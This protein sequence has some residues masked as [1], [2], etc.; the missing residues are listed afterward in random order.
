MK[1][2]GIKHQYDDSFAVCWGKKIDENEETKELNS[3]LS[4][5]FS[6]VLR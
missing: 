3:L 4:W 6:R 5:S 1:G 2:K